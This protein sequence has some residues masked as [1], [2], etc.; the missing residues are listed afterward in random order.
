MS[1]I[2]QIVFDKLIE[3][4]KPENRHP[5]CRTKQD[6]VALL[7]EIGDT[8][9]FSSIEELIKDQEA[10]GYSLDDIGMR[11]ELA[12]SDMFGIDT[13]FLKIRNMQTRESWGVELL[14]L[15]Q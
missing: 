11:A 6:V 5:K 10:K 15:H 9:D 3:A 4:V 2:K 8:F 12:P 13:L 7:H 14:T 1:N